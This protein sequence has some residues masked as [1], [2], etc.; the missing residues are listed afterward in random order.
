MKIKYL[1]LTLSLALV[2]TTGYAGNSVNTED[3]PGG[4][5]LM[6]DLMADK[7]TL[8]AEKQLDRQLLK[9]EKQEY[10]AEKRMAWFSKVINKKMAKSKNKALGGLDD[11]VDKY[12]W[13][14]LIGW[15]AGLLLTIIASAIAVGGAFSGGF[16]VAWVLFLVGWLCWIG[17]T[18]MGIIW[19]VKKFG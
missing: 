16:G 15:G 13:Y 11:P 6:E 19:L 14:W 3:N 10:R 1:L 9:A 8:K 2:V 7:A 5:V 18:V 12:F 4:G 17:G